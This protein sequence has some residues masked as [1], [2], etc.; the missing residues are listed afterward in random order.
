MEARNILWQ[1]VLESRGIIE[2]NK[3][4]AEEDLR[5]H[6]RLVIEVGVVMAHLSKEDGGGIVSETVD[7]PMPTAPARA[8]A[9]RAHEDKDAP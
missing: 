7:R 3:E 8:Y 9:M 4:V 2:V 1:I 6:L 5:Y